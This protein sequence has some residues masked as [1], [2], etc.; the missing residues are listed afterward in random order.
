[1]L[2]PKLED[3]KEGAVEEI[4]AKELK[5]P[6]ISGSAH[7]ISSGAVVEVILFPSI[8]YLWDHF[9]KSILSL[10]KSKLSTP[11]SVI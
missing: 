4:K 3:T 9:K 6:G 5:L 11:K 7:L 8:I 10:K 1:M 2:E